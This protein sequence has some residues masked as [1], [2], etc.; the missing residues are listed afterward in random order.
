MKET[1]SNKVFTEIIVLLP[2]TYNNII[3]SIFTIIIFSSSI[4][5]QII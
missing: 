5:M 4:I 1:N 3:V 2:H